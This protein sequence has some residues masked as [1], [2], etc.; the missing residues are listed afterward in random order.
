MAYEVKLQGKLQD[1][2]DSVNSVYDN[3]IEEGS[4]PEYAAKVAIRTAAAIHGAIPKGLHLGNQDAM[5]LAL[6]I[7]VLMERCRPKAGDDDP[8]LQLALGTINKFLSEVNE[9]ALDSLGLGPDLG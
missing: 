8:I 4:Q 9:I 5:G 6:S 7:S 1:V 2:I 3:L